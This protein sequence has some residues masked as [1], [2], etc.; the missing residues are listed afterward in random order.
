MRAM[1]LQ[2]AQQAQQH[3]RLPPLGD[4]SPDSPPDSPPASHP[5]SVPLGGPKGWGLPPPKEN[6]APIETSQTKNEDAGLAN[7]VQQQQAAHDKA[8]LLQLQQQQQRSLLNKLTGMARPAASKRPTDVQ[9]QLQF[10]DKPPGEEGEEDEE[11]DTDEGEEEVGNGVKKKKKKKR[12]QPP[13]KIPQRFKCPMSI[14][15]SVD[16]A[17]Y[18][19]AMMAL[20]V[21]GEG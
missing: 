14:S 8:Q 16:T 1:K 3:K 2:Q 12:W 15:G 18:Q 21:R 10:A 13:I 5:G 17:V 6:S 9:Q 11:G 4:S 20:Q 19:S 7:L